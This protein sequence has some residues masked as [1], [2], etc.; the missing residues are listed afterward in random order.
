MGGNFGKMSRFLGG[1]REMV[2]FS[3]GKDGPEQ[4]GPKGAKGG[5]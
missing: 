3:G 4:K 5:G 1:M 2:T